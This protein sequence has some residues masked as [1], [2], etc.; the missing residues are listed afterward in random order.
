MRLKAKV[1][2]APTRPPTPKHR[3]STRVLGLPQSCASRKTSFDLDCPSKLHPQGRLVEYCTD[4]RALPF[5]CMRERRG[6]GGDSRFRM[7]RGSVT[8]MPETHGRRARVRPG[9]A[10]ARRD[11]ASNRHE[12]AVWIHDLAATPRDGQLRGR[13]ASSVARELPANGDGRGSIG[14]G[15]ILRDRGL[16][17]DPLRLA[18]ACVH[19]G[20]HFL[21]PVVLK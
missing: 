7:A 8:G 2:N 12:A 20:G 9:R 14:G 1:R 17:V 13:D 16:P 6:G 21:L 4:C 10:P 15:R 5:C 3:A 19:S 11:A 18:F